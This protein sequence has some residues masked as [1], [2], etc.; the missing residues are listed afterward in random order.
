[1]KT[2]TSHKTIKVILSLFL[3]FSVFLQLIEFLR[4]T[5]IIIIPLKRM[6][7][8]R[9]LKPAVPQQGCLWLD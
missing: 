2:S 9:A 4:V 8:V 3:A 5:T 6:P 7:A 1:M